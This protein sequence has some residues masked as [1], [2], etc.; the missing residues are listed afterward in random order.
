M[1]ACVRVPGPMGAV[2]LCCCRFVQRVIGGMFNTAR[3]KR[4]AILGFSYKANTT[5]TRDSA[6]I[7]VC[8]GLMADGAAI[9]VH[10]PRVRPQ[11]Y[12]DMA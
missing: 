7:D 12:A 10:D 11:A 4:I 6:A 1:A 3:N 5:D 2:L 9:C 8:R